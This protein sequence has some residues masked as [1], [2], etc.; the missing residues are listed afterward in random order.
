MLTS[1]LS[2]LTSIIIIPAN[3]PTRLQFPDSRLSSLFG[4]SSR[5]FDQSIGDP[6]QCVVSYRDQ[7]AHKHTNITEY[8]HTESYLNRKPI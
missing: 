2:S 8:K 1:L 5:I 6:I 7:C 4:F 3:N